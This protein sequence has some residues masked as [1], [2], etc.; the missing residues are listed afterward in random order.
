MCFP[1]RHATGYRAI[2]VSHNHNIM[3]LNCDLIRFSPLGEQKLQKLDDIKKITI[4]KKGI[5]QKT[6]QT[7]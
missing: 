3:W 6:M 1:N 2:A 7:S 5:G 4:S